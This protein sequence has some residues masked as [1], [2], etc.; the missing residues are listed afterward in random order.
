MLAAK[1]ATKLVGSNSFTKSLVQEYFSL[2]F[3]F[4]LWEES[5]GFPRHARWR[6]PS[7]CQRALCL[8]N[9]SVCRVGV[10]GALKC[11]KPGSRRSSPLSAKSSPQSWWPSGWWLSAEHH[12]DYPQKKEFWQPGPR[13]A[14]DCNSSP[15]LVTT[16]PFLSLSLQ[17]TMMCFNT[18]QAVTKRIKIL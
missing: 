13:A 1:L 3:P 14:F 7:S 15:Y 16:P 5:I 9:C 17:T 8:G 6:V 10:G 11:Y 12:N 4:F 18:S 2:H